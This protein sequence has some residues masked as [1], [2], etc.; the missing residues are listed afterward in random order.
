M[1][2]FRNLLTYLYEHVFYICYDLMSY[3]WYKSNII[4]KKMMP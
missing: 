2:V 4:G 3:V 1:K